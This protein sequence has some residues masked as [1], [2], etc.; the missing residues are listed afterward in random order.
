MLGLPEDSPTNLAQTNRAAGELR[1]W[2]ELPGGRELTFGATGARF[3]SEDVTALV[4]GP[5]GV[6]LLDSGFHPDFVEG[7]GYAELRNP[8]TEN[9][10]V[11]LRGS[12]RHRSFDDVS[13]ADH[14]EASG[15]LGLQSRLPFGV[16]LDLAGGYGWLDSEGAGSEPH[17]IGR[18]GL[19]WRHASGLDFRLGFHH[20]LTTD[21]VGNDFVDTTG[22]ISVEKYFGLRTSATVTGFLSQLDSDSLH[23]SGNL[24][25]GAEVVV[26]RQ[27]SRSFQVSLAYRYWE[28]A[29]GFELDDFSQNQ[30]SLTFS[31]RR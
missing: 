25:G 30:A 2:R 20:E 7:G 22:R 23:P 31:Y 27:L 12:A 29:G 8:I 15:L 11:M 9:H 4:P 19:G 21:L 26:R 24:F 3:D 6:A 14:L 13:D 5:G 10:A 28:N 17:V 1:Y 16:D 18:A